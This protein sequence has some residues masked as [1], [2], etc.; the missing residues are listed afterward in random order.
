MTV[1]W[2]LFAIS[3]ATGLVGWAGAKYYGYQATA[4]I[5]EWEAPS[6]NETDQELDEGVVQ[7]QPAPLPNWDYV[8]K[9]ISFWTW[10]LIGAWAAAG[11]LMWNTLWHTGHWIWMRRT[12]GRG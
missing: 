11:I 8:E 2:A 12:V 3:S 7:L 1:C 10:G 5:S 9:Q 6:A 4:S